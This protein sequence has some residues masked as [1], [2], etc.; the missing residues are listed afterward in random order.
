[1]SSL[2]VDSSKKLICIGHTTLDTFLTIDNA[3][4]H[5]DINKL[6]CKVCF[7]FG[8]KIP[9]KDVYYGVGGG[10]ANV[11]VGARKLGI[12]ASI[13]TVLGS[14]T[15]GEDIKSSLKSHEVDIKKIEHDNNPTDQS[16]IVSYKHDRT[17]F[18]YSYP[19]KHSLTGLSSTNIFLSSVGDDVRTL[20]RDIKKIKKKY[21]YARLFFNPGSRELKNCRKEIAGILKYVDY[22][23]A[24]I[25]EGC[26]ILNSSLKPD[27][28]DIEDL[29]ELL[30][31]KGIK[32]VV[33]TAG[34]AGAY[35]KDSKKSYKVSAVKSEFVEK[36]GAGDA[37]ASGFIASILYEHDIGA[38]LKW[39]ALNSSA[40]ITKIGAQNG[41]LSK[42]EIEN[43]IKKI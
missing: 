27:Q 32:N 5:C 33:L 19:R 43:R 30:V 18:T 8:S 36:T 9:V 41:L 10:A 7:G 26:Q 6:D 23:V 35:A 42:T 1:M 22:L 14:D 13:Y 21:P 17:I 39:G 11:S 25:E 37:F 38:G 40:V 28:I 15:K 20:Y 34:K 2:P 12:N 16:V 3:E 24:N 4:V 29:M 31:E